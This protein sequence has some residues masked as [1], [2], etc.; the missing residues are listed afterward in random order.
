MICGG[1]SRF[2]NAND[3]QIRI[4]GVKSISVKLG[5]A[6]LPLL[7]A[8]NGALG[9][10]HAEE[11]HKL[12][13]VTS[14]LPVYCFTVNVAGDL[15]EVDNLLPPGTEPHD[16]QFSPR[17][18]RKLEAA[19]VV[20][21]NGLHLESWLD[22]AIK[23]SPNAKVIVEAAADFKSELIYEDSSLDA[24]RPGASNPADFGAPNPHV[25]LDPRLAQHEVTN[26]LA[27]LSKADPINA[28]A[29]ARN[30]GK[31]I[32]RLEKLDAELNTSLVPF[33]GQSIIT[34]HDAFPYFARRYGLKVAGVV[35]QVP[36]VQPSPKYLSALNQL[37][38]RNGI[39]VIF[40]ER[41]SPMKLAEQIGRDYKVAVAQL[42][43][44]ETG[45]FNPDAYEE[46]MRSNLRVLEKY[47][48]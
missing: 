17:E 38:R 25:W 28:A 15:A 22:R 46:G 41:Q 18:V 29:Y 35:E 2:R 21:V 19:D 14:F 8:F 48:K 40:A 27:A 37:I 34:F 24:E 20:V 4:G 13:V 11:G 33:Q 3:L 42:D 10:I 9:I 5:H 12:K 43:T 23:S 32:A 47:L 45:T 6:I 1:F 39:K 16:F 36:D 31:Y 44:L 7:L 30:A 26:I